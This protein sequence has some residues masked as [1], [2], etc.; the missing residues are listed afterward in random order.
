[1]DLQICH[2]ERRPCLWQDG[3]LHAQAGHGGQWLGHALPF[4]DLERG[5]AAVRRQPVRRPVGDLP[6]FHRRGGPPSP[7]PPP[8]PPPPPPI[9][10]PIPTSAWSRASRRRCC[11]P[12]RRATG[13][14]RAASPTPPIPRRS[15]SKCAFPTRPPIP[16]SPSRRF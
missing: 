8:P 5:A 10:R 15:G 12:I 13:R 6:L 14:R 4:L 16:I 3:H 1:A 9:P 7:R 11:S 2:P